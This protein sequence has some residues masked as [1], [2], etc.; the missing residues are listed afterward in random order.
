[1]RY[2]SRNK[3]LNRQPGKVKNWIY[4]RGDIYLAII[5]ILPFLAGIY[6]KGLP[7]IT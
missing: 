4:N 7:R 6:D 5:H 3:K 2:E 1:M